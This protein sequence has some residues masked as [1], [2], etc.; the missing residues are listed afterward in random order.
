VYVVFERGN[1]SSNNTI[2]TAYAELRD[3][4]APFD[5]AASAKYSPLAGVDLSAVLFNNIEGKTKANA[6]SD[7][8][9]GPLIDLKRPGRNPR[10]F[11]RLLEAGRLIDSV[12]PNAE[13][14]GIKYYCFD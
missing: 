1:T 2:R 3:R 8:C 11:Y 4:G 9:L 7:Q 10:T 14:D 13:T 5:P 6:L 12:V